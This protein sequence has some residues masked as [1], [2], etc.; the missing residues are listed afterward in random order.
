ELVIRQEPVTRTMADNGGFNTKRFSGD[1]NDG[2]AAYKVWKRWAKAAVVVQTARN[3]PAEALGPWLYT[4]LDGQAALAVENVDL[5]EINVESGEEVVFA[6]LDERFP[7][8][9]AADRLGEAMEDGF[10][11]R[12]Q[13]QETTEAYTWRA[14]LV[15]ARLPTEGVDLPSVA[16]G[17][18]ILRGAR[19]GNFGRATVMSAT[20]LSW[21]VDEVCTAIRTAFPGIPPERLTQAACAVEEEFVDSEAP[22]PPEPYQEEGAEDDVTQE[23]DAIVQAAEPI[24]ES[25]AVEILATWKQTRVAMN[26][27][28]LDRGLRPGWK[29]RPPGPSGPTRHDLDKL[30]R[31]VKFFRCKNIGHFSRDCKEALPAHGAGMVI[32]EPMEPEAAGEVRVE[33]VQPC[34]EDN[35]D[36][37]INSILKVHEDNVLAKLIQE[38]RWKRLEHGMKEK[39][40]DD[41]ATPEVKATEE[42]TVLGVAH[43]DGCSVPDTGCCKTLIGEE[44]L[45]K[46]EAATG[47]KA[48][49]LKDVR[50]MRFRGLDNGVQ[51]S[52]GA[53]ELDWAIKNYIVTF[54]VYVVPGHCE[55]DFLNREKRT[56]RQMHESAVRVQKVA[57]SEGAPTF[58]WGGVGRGSWGQSL[59]KARGW[60]VDKD[61]DY[62]AMWRRIIEDEPHFVHVRPPCQKLTIT[63][64]CALLERRR[65]LAQHVVEVKWSVSFVRAVVEVA[66]H[67]MERGRHFVYE[68]P[69]RCASLQVPVMRQL[70]QTKGVC[71]GIASGCEFGLRCPDALKLIRGHEHQHTEGMLKC[72]VKRTVFSQRYPRRLVEAIVRGMPRQCQV[73]ASD[74]EAGCAAVQEEGE[75]EVIEEGADE[76]RDV[77]RRPRSS[78]ENSLRKLRVQLG[79]CKNNVLVR[80]LRRAHAAEQAIKAAQEFYC[81]ECEGMKCPKVA[82]RSAPA[83]AHLPLKYVSMDC[84]D[85]PSWIPG[86]R[87]TCLGIIDETSSLRQV[88]PRIG[89]KEQ[90]GKIEHHNQVFEIILEDVTREAQPQTETEWRECVTELVLAKNS[91]LSVTG[92]S[93]MQVVFG[94]NPEVPGDLLMDSPDLITNSAIV[95]DPVAAQQA[96]IRAIARV[97]VLM[98]QD[99]LAA[100]RALDSRPR[101]VARYRPGDVVAAWRMMKNKGIPN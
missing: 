25:D 94:R 67:Q 37:E 61:S 52:I 14:Q 101:V 97:K 48:K 66:I 45:M 12:I 85:L 86:E 26:K 75:H 34:L 54:A 100:R 27:E 81:P 56:R 38:E 41:D 51:E 79:H 28:R 40:E 15:F 33:M 68:T 20:H 22:P 3:T 83:E 32:A 69:L 43:S 65:N 60:D 44:T 88:E 8:K 87:I 59:D 55:I 77:L 9:V 21:N 10:S 18:L 50:P 78:I 93:P 62:E 17:Y 2:A 16:R 71:V 30:G 82:R 31:R 95:N 98:Q 76:T 23:I 70:L 6:R 57:E 4:L 47:K 64:Q 92:A 91:L 1:G 63:Q 42:G 11:L 80:H 5:S 39:Q 99:M 89:A 53:V 58:Q 72:G 13:K 49:W 96:R 35:L 7:D 90:N 84:K 24:E 46:H 36:D 29:A 19:L 73:V 74:P